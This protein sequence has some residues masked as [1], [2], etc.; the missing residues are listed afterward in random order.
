ME[1]QAD[2]QNVEKLLLSSV[3]MTLKFRFVKLLVYALWM[4][5]SGK[6]GACICLTGLIDSPRG[7]LAICARDH[8]ADGG[9][10][11]GHLL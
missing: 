10:W 11:C 9:W 1:L 3:R 7:D 8:I 2:P 5:A 6:T 4:D